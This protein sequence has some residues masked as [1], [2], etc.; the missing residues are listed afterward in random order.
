MN[1]ASF[2]SS[3]LSHGHNRANF[4]IDWA[5]LEGSESSAVAFSVVAFAAACEVTCDVSY[6]SS[7]VDIST[8]IVS[9]SISSPSES[10]N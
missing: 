1:F 6:S 5:F 2:R 9:V 4:S 3:V 8:L 10:N 7:D